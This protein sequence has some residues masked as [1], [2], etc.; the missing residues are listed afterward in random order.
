[1]KLLGKTDTPEKADVYIEAVGS[2]NAVETYLENVR[3][4]GQIILVGNPSV[5]FKIE[6]KLYWQILRKQL[7]LTGSWNSSFPCDWDG[8]I[9]NIKM[10]SIDKLAIP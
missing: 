3:P 1:V 9:K 8:V 4:N 5:D 2:C 6:Q 10:L 7:T